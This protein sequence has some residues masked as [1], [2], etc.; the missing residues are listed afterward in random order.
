MDLDRVY[1]STDGGANWTPLS[2]LP[3]GYFRLAIAPTTPTTLYAGDTGWTYGMFKSTNGGDSWTPVDTFPVLGVNTITIDPT[4]PTTL[5]VG[6]VAGLFKSTNGGATW[7]AANSGLRP[8]GS[9]DDIRIQAL[10]IDPTSPATLYVVSRAR[11]DSG[12]FKSIDGG[13]N[14]TAIDGALSGST[15]VSALVIDPTTPMTLYAGTSGLYGRYKSGG[16]YKSVDGGVTWTAVLTGQ[17][18][19]GPPLN[20]F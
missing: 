9:N 15:Y 17:S 16:V 3:T 6:T 13:G 1:K 2:G 4:T 8:P 14:W 5:Y 20:P 19:V 7:M 18:T 10:V 12:L 11:P